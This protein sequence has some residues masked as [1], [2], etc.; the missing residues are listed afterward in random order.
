MKSDGT[1]A[2]VQSIYDYVHLALWASLM[3][4]VLFFVAFT[5]PKL[6]EGC[7][8]SRKTSHSGNCTGK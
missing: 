7:C 3:A 8:T 4:L 1:L 2:L 6:P 5:V